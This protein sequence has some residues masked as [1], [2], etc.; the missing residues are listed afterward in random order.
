MEGS[1]NGAA[2]TIDHFSSSGGFTASKLKC[3]HRCSGRAADRPDTNQ[4]TAGMSFLA[5]AA[6]LIWV[7][8]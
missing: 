4:T 8:R 5:N 6:V 1:E 2:D 7:N 3:L